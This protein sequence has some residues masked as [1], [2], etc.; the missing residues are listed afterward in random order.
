MIFVVRGIIWYGL[1]LFLILLP[2]ATAAI[3]NPARASQPLLVEIAVGAGFIGFALMSL[4]FDSCNECHDAHA[5]VVKV[6][7]CSACH[8]G[9][10]TEAD[11]ANIRTSNIDYD[12]DGDVVEGLSGEIETMAARLLIAMQIYTAQTDGVGLIDHD[13]GFV[14]EAG[15]SYTTWTPRLLQAAYNYLYTAKDPGG[16]SHNGEYLIQ[17]LYDDSLEDIGGVTA[18]LTRPGG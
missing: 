3:A 5:L 12:G 18:G 4:E 13:G 15:E 11:L 6:E 17:L 7:S 8:L 9:V 10:R 2:L 1:Y 16:Y 14:D